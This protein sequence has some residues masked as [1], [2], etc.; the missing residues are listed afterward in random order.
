MTQ[1]PTATPLPAPDV[2]GVINTSVQV[3][4]DSV[5]KR[6]GTLI[7]GSPTALQ[8][9]LS[10]YGPAIVRMIQSSGA[11]DLNSLYLQLSEMTYSV[12]IDQIHQSMTREE[13]EV[14]S[15]QLVPMFAKMASDSAN[16]QA[17]AKQIIDTAFSLAI[18]LA[19][20]AIVP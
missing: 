16:A 4:S 18:S 11:Q 8:P 20:K 7:S 19:L 5:I 6:L 10:A 2:S 13:L 9:V 15:G 3:L 12:S 17:L 14:E 1:D